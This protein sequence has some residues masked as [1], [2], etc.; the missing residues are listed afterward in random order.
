MKILP[1]AA[2]LFRANARTDG[3]DEA[4]GRFSHFCGNAYKR[5]S[6][7]THT[8]LSYLHYTNQPHKTA[9]ATVH[10]YCTTNPKHTKRNFLILPLA[11]CIT[12]VTNALQKAHSARQ[13]RPAVPLH[14]SAT[15]VSKL[16]IKQRV[17]TF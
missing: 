4:N 8:E 16:V 12:S 13:F 14:M 6:C 2:E 15:A 11:V 7:H 9:H 3:H 17:Q 5:T 1:V 10:V